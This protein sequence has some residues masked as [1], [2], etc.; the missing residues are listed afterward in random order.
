MTYSKMMLFPVFC[1]QSQKLMFSCCFVRNDHHYSIWPW[2]LVIT[3]FWISFFA[4]RYQVKSLNLLPCIHFRQKL[5]ELHFTVQHLIK[6]VSFIGKLLLWFCERVTVHVEGLSAQLAVA[7]ALA[8]TVWMRA[9]FTWCH[10]ANVP[11]LFCF[12]EFTVFPLLKVAIK[13]IFA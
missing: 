11:S 3:F 12:F 8:T 5:S 2:A 7:I 6:L 4:Q 1:I 13:F 9:D 10:N